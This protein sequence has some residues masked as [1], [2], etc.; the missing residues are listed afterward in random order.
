M[1]RQGH[2]FCRKGFSMLKNKTVVIGLCV[3][4]AV[5]LVAL[6]FVERRFPE[7]GSEFVRGLLSHS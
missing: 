4:L 6:I 5:V 7:A 3:V 2:S 1:M